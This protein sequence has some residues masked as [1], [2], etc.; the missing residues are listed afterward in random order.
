MARCL[1]THAELDADTKVEHTI[2]RALG[3]RVRSSEVTSSDFNERC[4]GRVDPYFSG[5]YAETMRALGP[6]L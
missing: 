1:F 5:V 3:G 4:G 2:Q 6:R